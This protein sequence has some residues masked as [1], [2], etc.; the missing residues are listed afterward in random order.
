MPV[1]ISRQVD[2]DRF[3]PVTTAVKL[4]YTPM[5]RTIDARQA[6][7]ELPG[8]TVYHLQTF[9]KIMDAALDSDC[10]LVGITMSD[11]V[12]VYFN[13]WRK[14]RP[15]LVIGRSG[16]GFK[17]VETARSDL[18]VIVFE[19]ATERFDWPATGKALSTL[20]ITEQSQQALRDLIRAAFRPALSSYDS[21]STFATALRDV[22]VDAITDAIAGSDVDRTRQIA[23]RARY[24][25]LVQRVDRYFVAHVGKPIYSEQ[26]AQTLGVSVRTLSNA[27][28]QCCGMSLHRYL[29][30][31]RLWLV[32]KALLAGSDS[33][34]ACALTHGFWH[35]SDFTSAYR[36]QFGETPSQTRER[37]S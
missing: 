36:S 25:E 30:L 32:R 9:P 2:L 7:L 3:R 17:L 23:E 22:F 28:T 33:I 4:D 13:G 11:D 34:K 24:F 29:R 35:M 6:V 37:A 5:A 16:G 10:T 21:D 31:K 8:C 18:G 19:P 14:N 12:P 27:V 15:A 20:V 1:Q 26:L